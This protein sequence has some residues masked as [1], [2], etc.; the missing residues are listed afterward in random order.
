M[1]RKNINARAA[2]SNIHDALDEALGSAEWR[3]LN[4]DSQYALTR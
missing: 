2:E 3:P 1:G 4:F